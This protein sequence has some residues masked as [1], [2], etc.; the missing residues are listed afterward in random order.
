MSGSHSVMRSPRYVHAIALETRRHGHRDRQACRMHPQV[1][2]EFP[3]RPRATSRPATGSDPC[4]GARPVRR[5]GSVATRSAALRVRT[6]VPRRGRAVRRSRHRVPASTRDQTRTDPPPRRPADSRT[7]APTPVGTGVAVRST[8]MGSGTGSSSTSQRVLGAAVGTLCT[9]GFLD[10]EVHARMR[11]PQRHR[12]H[13]A[14]QRQVRRSDFVGLRSV[15]GDL[16]AWLGV[17][18]MACPPLYGLAHPGAPDRRDCRAFRRN[19]RAG[20]RGRQP[21]Q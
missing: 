4:S 6:T 9:A 15:R 19:I 12:G 10:G 18:V 3:D 16:C 2:H 17:Q 13:R 8:F 20:H 11:I 7:Q 5:A 1:E 14:G 21:F